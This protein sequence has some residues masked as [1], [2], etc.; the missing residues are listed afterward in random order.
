LKQVLSDYQHGAA[1]TT[2]LVNTSARVR[3]AGEALTD[4]SALTRFLD[5]QGALTDIPRRVTAQDLQSVLE[6][7]DRLRELLER[8]D[9]AGLAAGANGLLVRAGAT[10]SLERDAAGRWHWTVQAD[11]SL[12]VGVQ[13]G[14]AVGIGLLGVLR[15]LGHERVR[16]CADPTC[17]GMFVDTSKAGRRRYCTPERC[18]NRFNVA[19]FRQRR[20]R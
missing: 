3:D 12:P 19:R 16:A 13:L 11:P 2:A 9:A 18:G 7:R 8:S 14:V 4:P 20:G 10:P 5:E 6:L 1:L 17:D 15:T